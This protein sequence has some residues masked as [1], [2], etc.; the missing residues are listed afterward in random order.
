MNISKKIFL[1][2]SLFLLTGCTA[3]YTLT[4]DENGIE[5]HIEWKNN[6]LIQT[7]ASDG[8][9]TSIKDLLYYAYPE[10]VDANMYEKKITKEGKNYKIELDYTHDPDQFE[11]AT[12]LQYFKYYVFLNGE[13]SY[14]LNLKGGLVEGMENQIEN[15]IQVKIITHNR[16]IQNNADEIKGDTYIWNITKNNAPKKE[17]IFQVSKNQ[18]EIIQKDGNLVLTFIIVIALLVLLPIILWTY[19]QKILDKVTHRDRI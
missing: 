10:E 12:A 19:G 14:Y 7:S 6:T 17:I 15:T 16:V 5:E 13:S 1:I 8:T 11:K 4:F 3:S 18:K 9:E 2:L